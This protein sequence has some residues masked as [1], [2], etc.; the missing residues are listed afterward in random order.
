MRSVFVSSFRFYLV[1]IIVFCLF[2]TFLGRLAYLQVWERP[3]LLEIVQGNR[4][5]FSTL[6]A[7][8]GNIVDEKGNLLATTKSV[9]EIGVDPQC[10]DPEQFDSIPKLATLLNI[11]ES[12]ARLAFETKTRPGTRYDN[13][14]LPVRWTKLVDSVDEEIYQEVLELGISGVYGTRKHSRR[15]PCDRLG[16]HVLGF[17]N[18]EGV[19][20]MGV[21]KYMDFYLS[22]QDGWRESEKD[23]HRRELAQYR[24]REISPNNG[25]NVQLTL[26]RMIQDV[27][28]K[29]LAT[30]VKQFNP[31]SATILVG[32]PATGYLV[33]LGN[34][35]DFDPNRFNEFE[36]GNLRN[37]ALSDLYE[38]G[39][40]FKIV[41]AGAALDE[42][43]AEMEEVI[44]CSKAVAI[45]NGRELRLPGD[46][47]P[48]GK[49]SLRKVISK[50]SNRGAAQLGLRLG[51]NRLY[52][53]CRGF[54]FGERSG[55]GIGAE[56]PGILHPVR[57]WDSLTITRLP[58][59]HAVGVTPMQVHCAMGAVAN[60]GVL[61]KPQVVQRIYNQHGK[62]V[63]SFHPI[64]RR[65]VLSR[66]TS[67][68]LTGALVEVVSDQ[69][70]AKNAAVSGFQVAG[71]TGT[72]QK[73][74]EGRYS[75]EKHV[76]SFSGFLPADRPRVVITVVVNEPRFNGT[77]YGSTCAAPSFRKIAEELVAYLGIQPENTSKASKLDRSGN[78]LTMINS[79]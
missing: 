38:P 8:R 53:Y 13:E 40:T 4:S 50:S 73:L 43:I 23:G 74:V 27:V 69:G 61:M 51:E 57:K 60:G 7:K 71:K 21:E 42:G 9:V 24:L 59:G 10:V 33:G 17:V 30:I 3:N 56:H 31:V 78:P 37:R 67:T 48:L 52:S 1:F 19:A 36:M 63:A 77:G 58:M 70:T 68:L 35:P 45:H 14:V 39:S 20:S 25:L 65:R 72:T 18:R 32:E 66:Q 75:N 16:S 6:Q 5:N 15:Y 47:H 44:D 11:K 55:F 62:T 29:E 2:C 22:G 64:A 49:L 46:H 54:G 76:A 79:Q 12:K 41:A 26:N 28:E 34:Y